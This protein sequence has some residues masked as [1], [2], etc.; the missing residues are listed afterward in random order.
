MKRKMK[1]GIA[2]LLTVCVLICC[3]V[4]AVA[5]GAGTT[6]EGTVTVSNGMFKPLENAQVT[7]E[8]DKMTADVIYT[9]DAFKNIYL[10]TAEQAKS[11]LDG[12]LYT[13]KGKS[14]EDNKTFTIPISQLGKKFDAAVLSASTGE[15]KNNEITIKET[16]DGEKKLVSTLDVGITAIGTMWN[17]GT[18][19]A[20]SGKLQVYSDGTM[21]AVITYNKTSFDAL[22]K[23]SYNEVKDVPKTDPKVVSLKDGKFVIPVTISE[24][25]KNIEVTL[26]SKSNDKWGTVSSE[27]NIKIT[28]KEKELLYTKTVTI[29]KTYSMFKPE[30]KGTVSVYS[31]G[32][33]EAKITYKGTSF[34][35]MYLG[36]AEQATS[37]LSGK[38][39][40]AKGSKEETN[41]TFTIPFSKSG[42]SFAAAILSTSTGEWVDNNMTVTV[43]EETTTAK[44]TETTTE[45]PTATNPG[46]RQNGTYSISVNSSASMFRVVSCS[47]KMKDGI[48]TAT[49][50]LS[51]TGYDYL[52]LGKAS[53]ASTG[54][55]VKFV[56]DASGNY[57]YTIP[58]SALDTPISVAAHSI[59]TD[60]WYDRELTFQSDTL[61]LVAAD[62]G[63]GGDTT[64]NTSGTTENQGSGTTESTNKNNSNSDKNNNNKNNKNDK[65][66][67]ELSE[68]DIKDLKNNTTS[69]TVKDGTYT[70]SFGFTGGSG[71][72]N[73]TCNKVVVKNGKATATIVFSSS[74]Y[75]WVKVNGTKYD[76]E[77]KGGNSTF[78]IPVKLNGS[79]TITAQTTAMSAAHEIEYVLY[80]YI[81]GTVVK[82][83]GGGTSS[84]GSTEAADGVVDLTG[85]TEGA[86]SLEAGTTDAN[87]WGAF[88]DTG[89][90]EDGE[91]M[92]QTGEATVSPW[93]I[94]LCIF[95]GILDLYV[96][97]F[98][99]FF[100]VRW[101]KNKKKGA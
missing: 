8:G 95:T 25:N 73:I 10:G 97:G 96:T 32:S 38:V 57:T 28:T 52:Y 2:M 13:A 20:D 99:I 1:N 75:T 54:K 51:G 69:G 39:Y 46:G 36:T 41:K 89:V 66:K 21:E 93:I 22:C 12:I 34:V 60:S 81:D 76:N 19:V 23:G 50:T 56:T 78:T 62:T 11:A 71:K 100:F 61:Q 47:L 84:T 74:S 59:R 68:E 98:S 87:S 64:G 30:N 82:S 67:G 5:N 70:P 83:S 6:K 72:T 90:V 79:T 40:S 33:M 4:P 24:L 65:N 3:M 16:E 101:R 48:M 77:N 9:G 37:A 44:P 88:S 27:R 94:A 35:N 45:T 55:G 42:E 15:W 18:Q 80:C 31:D 63:T 85:E 49:L 14:G 58:V 53:G 86:E 17:S 43:K 26:W 91:Q 7:V 29:E 92:A